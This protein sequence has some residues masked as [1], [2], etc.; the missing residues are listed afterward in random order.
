MIY[1]SADT[2][3][4]HDNTLK[5]ERRPFDTKEKFDKYVIDTWNSQVE[6]DDTIYVLG[7]FLNFNWERN[8]KYSWVKSIY[9]PRKLKCD[10]ILIIGN[11]EERL[12]KKVF[13]NNFELFRTFAINAGFKDVKK[14]EILTY[15][16]QRFFLNHYPSKHK[17]GFINLFGHVH[18][19]TGLYKPFGLNV[20]CDLNY[21]KLYSFDEIIEI[22]EQ[23]SVFWDEDID[24][25]A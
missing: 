20:G 3:F 15:N 8:D 2:H 25:N 9:Y 18:R 1:F 21:F 14:E 17:K 23:K 12:I 22:L 5:R 16:N 4:N 10:V 24:V 6:K 11:N 13:D 7:D 19:S